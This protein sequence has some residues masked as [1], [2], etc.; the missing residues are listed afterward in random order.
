ML[1]LNKKNGNEELGVFVKG[2]GVGSRYYEDEDINNVLC[3]GYE[4]D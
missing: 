3:Y 1:L 4:L 2:G